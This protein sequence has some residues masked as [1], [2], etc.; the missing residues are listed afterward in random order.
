[1]GTPEPRRRALLAAAALLFAAPVV[2]AQSGKV[3]RV[4]VLRPGSSKEPPSVQREPFERGLRELGWNPGS[5]V[6]IL[7][8][9]GEGNA[10]RLPELAAELIKEGV[11]VMV[12]PG[13]VPAQAIR[14][15]APTIPLVMAAA[16]D[17]VA[18]GFAESLARPGRNSTGI[19]IQTY[20]LD[21][22]R[23]EIL[24]EAF[25]QVRRVAVLADPSAE[26]F[27]YEK[28]IAELRAGAKRLKVAL[29]VFEIKSVEELA[30]AL[31]AIE[32]GRFDALLVRPEPRVMDTHRQQIAA[33]AAKLKLPAIYAFR[34]YVEAGGLM[35]YGESI[36]AFHH[37]SA[38]FVS[39]ILK[40]ARAGELAFERPTKFELIV[41]LKAA[42]ALG[43]EF[44]KAILFRADQVIQ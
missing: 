10:T 3:A 6:I 13:A 24:K 40:G 15:A 19:A 27:G 38:S 23:L 41:N 32:R 44:P 34:F 31:A 8:R 29:E 33:T 16:I 25:P 37:R 2:R 30:A 43:V 12:S 14:A 42:K 1:V 39:R 11:D 36:P 28:R 21:G 18:E 22:K 35:S 4:G 7:Y 17:P 20:D 9:Y 26:P 5:D